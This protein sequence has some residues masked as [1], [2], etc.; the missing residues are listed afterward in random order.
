VVT[1]KSHTKS[2]IENVE[3]KNIDRRSLVFFIKSC[4]INLRNTHLKTVSDFDGEEI[5]YNMLDFNLCLG[6]H[7]LTVYYR[8]SDCSEFSIT[9]FRLSY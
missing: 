6:T 7:S 2:F 1:G 9:I 8:L 3:E 4:I 5:L